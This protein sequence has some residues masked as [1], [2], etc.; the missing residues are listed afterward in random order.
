MIAVTNQDS[1]DGPPLSSD[2]CGGDGS[3][4]IAANASPNLNGCYVQAEASKNLSSFAYTLSGTTNALEVI[5]FS[6]VT[7]DGDVSCEDFV[8]RP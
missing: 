3:F 4:T 1:V 8:V 7:D 5:V 2:T 6:V